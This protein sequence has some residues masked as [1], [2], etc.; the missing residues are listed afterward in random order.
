MNTKWHNCK[1]STILNHM[2]T[3]MYK[4]RP[5]EIKILLID[6][7]LTPTLAIFQLH[8]HHGT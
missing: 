5:L 7:C 4:G 3:Y 6:W 2:I 8:V 1:I